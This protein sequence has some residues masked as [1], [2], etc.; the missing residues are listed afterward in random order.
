MSLLGQETE[1]NPVTPQMN[2]IV[3]VIFKTEIVIKLTDESQQEVVRYV[4]AKNLNLV[5][6]V[7]MSYNLQKQE[8]K[9]LKP[10]KLKMSP[11]SL[12]I[13]ETKG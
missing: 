9:I 13:T 10:N 5:S 7:N 4:A 3:N 6:K 2:I 11:D 12:V 8:R 1:Y